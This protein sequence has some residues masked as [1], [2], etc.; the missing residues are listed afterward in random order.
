MHS[1]TTR[2]LRDEVQRVIETMFR[3]YTSVVGLVALL[4]IMPLS[5]WFAW[6]DSSAP[7]LNAVETVFLLSWAWTMV[8]LLQMFRVGWDVGLTSRERLAVLS[9]PRPDDPDELR[10]W[11]SAWR[12]MFAL[13]FSM[14]AMIGIPLADWLTKK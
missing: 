6:R 12:F 11:K 3:G 2:Q 7:I 8:S 9:G 4:V 14:L 13:L 10:V 5:L 1:P